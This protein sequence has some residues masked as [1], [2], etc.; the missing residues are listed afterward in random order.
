MALKESDTPSSLTFS[1]LWTIPRLVLELSAGQTALLNV[2]FLVADDEI[3]CEYLLVGLTVLRHLGV[4]SRT[5][6]QR[7]WNT[8]TDTCC[9]SVV[10][11]AAS[12]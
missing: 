2:E 3:A 10:H 1:R 9:A 7:G 4:D 12:D 5:L 11:S 6:L 8:L